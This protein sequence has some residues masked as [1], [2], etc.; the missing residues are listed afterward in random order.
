MGIIFFKKMSFVQ[1]YQT[2][3]KT[4]SSFLI[5]DMTSSLSTLKTFVLDCQVRF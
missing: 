4:I 1:D 2:L 5:N 3:K